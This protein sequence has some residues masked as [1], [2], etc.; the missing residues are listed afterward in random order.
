MELS[1]TSSMPLDHFALHILVEQTGTE[2]CDCAV[3]FIVIIETRNIWFKKLGDAVT[4]LAR[5]VGVANWPG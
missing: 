4:I 2:K 5:L 3:F 1:N